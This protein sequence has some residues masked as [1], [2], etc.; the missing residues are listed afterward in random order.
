[1]TFKVDL[2]KH[3]S[4]II[5]VIGVGG[6]GGN[7][8][9][10]MYDKGIIGVDFIICNTDAQA[11]ESS[12]IPNKIQL[13]SSLTEGLGAGSEPEV[14]KQ[15]AIESLEQIK[16]ALSCNAKMVFITAGMGGGTGTGAAPV[17]AKLAKELDLLTVGIVTTPFK[18]E[19]PHK[20]ELAQSGIDELR[21]HV[22]A[23]LIITNDRILQMY[24]NLRYSEAFSKADDV[25][26]TATKGIAEII[27]KS[28]KL[29]VDF[30]DVQTAMKNSGRAIMGTGIASGDERA[31]NASQMALDS[32]LLDDTDIEGAKHI[33][34]NISY[35]THEPYTNEIDQITAF[36]Q[37][38]AG[39]KA[40]LKFGV[41]QTEGLG[42]NI[43]ITVIATGFDKTSSISDIHDDLVIEI[44]KDNEIEID[45]TDALDKESNNDNNQFVFPGKTMKNT[46]NLATI[47]NGG[48][49]PIDAT[50]LGFPTNPKTQIGFDA[51][52]QNNLDIPAYQRMG[53]VLEPIPDE[54]NVQKLYLEEKDGDIK[55][56]E[57]G[58]KF[59][60]KDV[61]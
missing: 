9:N 47:N 7:A 30:R 6:G 8:V 35:D 43:S 41:T 38:A 39:Q 58:N 57:T 23:L 2:P 10:Y 61:D 42:D 60:N 14:G 15:C 5:K 55:F 22:D 21:P 13:G 26:C 18:N 17:I 29:N 1:M 31:L 48:L 20:I 3:Q 32:P 33:L 19:G 24:H 4:S 51:V 50:N 37:N 27:T 34:L 52:N 44:D 16:E 40:R 36:F 25:L 46:E 45:L 56:K 11:L 12:P 49:F 53:L 28:G 54:K 59:L